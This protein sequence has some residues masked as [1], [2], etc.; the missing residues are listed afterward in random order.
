MRLMNTLL[1]LKTNS[2]FGNPFHAVVA[3]YFSVRLLQ[4][5]R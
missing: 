2:E 1:V 3:A 5:G 4:S